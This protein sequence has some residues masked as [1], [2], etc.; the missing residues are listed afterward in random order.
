MISVIIPIYD[1]TQ[2]LIEAIESILHQT[3]QNFELL[4]ITDGSPQETMEVV[5][6]YRNNA[7]IKIF[8]FYN[9]TGNAVRGRNKGIKESRGEFVAFL[10]SDDIAMPS[11]L[12]DSLNC[13][14]ETNVD[15]VYGGWKA[16]LEGTRK[17]EGLENGQIIYSPDCDEEMLLKV[18]VPCQSTVMVK[19]DVLLNVG[20]LKTKMNY[21]EDHELWLR[22]VHFGYQL[23]AIPKVL[24]I[25]RLHKGNN[26][27]VFKENDKH[28]EKELLKQYRLN[29]VLPKKICY[30]I[31]GSG[32]SGGIAVVLNHTNRL[33]KDGYDVFLLSQNGSVN[34]DWFP[35]NKVP[36]IPLNDK[37]DY[38]LNN[39][40]I[41]VATG[42]TTVDILK[43][44]DAKRKI[45]F[46]QSDERRF[47][48]DRQTQS[49]VHETYLTNCEY[50]TMAKW[51]QDWL[52]NEFHHDSKYIPNGLDVELFHE[53]TPLIPKGK[54]IRVLMEGPID[55]PFKGMDD[56]Y[57]VLKNLDCEI[58]IVSSSGKPKFGWRYDQFFEK[59]PMNEMK[60]IY[61]SCD[62]FL[63]MSRV[64]SFCYP[65]LEAMA[66]GLVPVVKNVTGLEEYAVHGKNA[67][68]VENIEEARNAV[69]NLIVD[70]QL[71]EKMQVEGLTTAKNWGWDLSFEKLQNI[72]E[73]K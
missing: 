30:I 69:L 66:C 71:R 40:D 35:N 45:Y 11:R 6:S 38:Y 70:V 16:Q 37:Y 18:C 8:H 20:G 60:N 64:E 1:R 57:E 58:W 15:M 31:P 27:L 14:L 26:E 61:S 55:I 5:E 36:I 9:Q 12:Q 68:I 49:L 10:D 2:E 63:K 39:I 21:R 48:E 54:K 62:I 50:V 72:I 51:I 7:K 44:I 73:N 46:V 42:W 17:I 3:Y 24:T 33:L 65:P 23:K 67:I 41:L 32:I 4:L 28:W 25:L 34:L 59:V 52:K 53:S 56:S 13:L 43:E 22:L 19:K 29:S 47:Y